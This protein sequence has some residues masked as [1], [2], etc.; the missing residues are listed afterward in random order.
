MPVA[1]G[2]SAP[3]TTAGVPTGTSGGVT[4]ADTP[5]A[6]GTLVR[7][8]DGIH[9]TG[10]V[11]VAR[12]SMLLV[13]CSAVNA[14]PLESVTTLTGSDQ[15]VVPVGRLCTSTVRPASAAPVSG[16]VNVTRT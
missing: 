15:G 1:A 8:R 11:Y 9:P 13:G 6:T 3:L 7:A 16:R 14:R 5:V 2:L 4:V 10:P 12:T